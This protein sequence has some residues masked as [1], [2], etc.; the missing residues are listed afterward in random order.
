MK[1]DLAD[2]GF[3]T[4]LG[5]LPLDGIR[6]LDLTR[7][8]S[9]PH[10]T[11][12]LAGLG[13]KVIRIDDPRQ[14]DPTFSAPPFLGPGG[15]SLRRMGPSDIGLAYLKRCRS[16]KAITLDLKQPAGHTLF[17]RLVEQ[18]DVVVENFRPGVMQ[19]LNLD[20]AVM[21]KANP[22]IIHCAISG[23]GATGPLSRKKSYDLMVQAASGLMA[24]TGE[25]DGPACKAGSPLSDGI[26]GT[27]A[28]AGILAALLQRGR[29]GR[30]Q[31]IDVSMLDCLFALLF[32]E[33]LDCY[34][35]LGL[36]LRQGNRIMRFSPFN[37]YPTRDGAI[38]IG[39][40]TNEDWLRLLAVIGREDLSKDANYMDTGWRVANNAL[41]DDTVATWTRTHTRAEAL[42]KLDAKEIACSAVNGIA[43]I[44][45][46]QH[47]R[48][49][50]M[51]QPLHGPGSDAAQGALA[52]G[53]PLRFSGADVG[54]H[55]PAPMPRAN[56]EEIY[57][58]LL[59]LSRA[60]QE[61]LAKAGVI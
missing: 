25:P 36:P 38:V 37:S 33:P 54:Y 48:D 2:G 10:A 39:A 6:V 1:I 49:R 34:D 40:A 60:D 32:D 26:A 53:F 52:A 27:Y 56:N 51:L 19:R 9:G 18:A 44:L 35:R 59:N 21:E 43:D 17:L 28:V 42:E 46:W 31:F 24:I 3:V 4:Q 61:E 5:I 45:K 23:Y 50:E 47:L 14:V 29:T 30:G 57:T 8:L 12:L 15:V 22:R 58:G 7:F 20:Y 13:A 55:R 41:I 11:L 16:K